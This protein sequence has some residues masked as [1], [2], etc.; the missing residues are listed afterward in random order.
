MSKITK[1]QLKQHERA[2]EFLWGSDRK[3]TV[4]EVA[5]CLEHWDPRAASG[6]HV[7]QNQ[8]QDL[9]ARKPSSSLVG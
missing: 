6:K 5:F 4:D 9:P 8:A 2:E 1:Q 7:A 3:L